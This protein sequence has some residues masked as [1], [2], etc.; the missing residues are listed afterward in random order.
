MNKDGAQIFKETAEQVG[1]PKAKPARMSTTT[2]R[3][4]VR[5]YRSP[6][7]TTALAEELMLPYNEVNARLHKL[8]KTGYIRKDGLVWRIN[9]LG[10]AL[11]GYVMEP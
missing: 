8:K 11:A 9:P 5:L 10:E 2:I 1:R 6:Y 4:L 7:M 3:I